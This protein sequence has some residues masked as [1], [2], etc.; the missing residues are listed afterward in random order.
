MK[1]HLEALTRDVTA[2]AT[3]ASW[4]RFLLA[5]S[6]A[7]GFI[8]SSR[9]RKEDYL[10]WLQAAGH[11]REAGAAYIR[12]PTAEAL[13]PYK[14][15]SAINMK[16]PTVSEGLVLSSTL[17]FVV[18]CGCGRRSAMV[19]LLGAPF[20]QLC[21]WTHRLSVCRHA[22]ALVSDAWPTTEILVAALCI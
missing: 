16:F 7:S 20:P 12:P 3:R 1:P 11:L 2:S 17:H 6:C 19:R 22:C 8:I 15:A 14:V 4:V 13:C 9:C 5:L 10:E 18:G 21:V